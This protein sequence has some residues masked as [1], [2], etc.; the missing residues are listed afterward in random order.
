MDSAKLLPGSLGGKGILRVLVGDRLIKTR[1]CNSVKI[2][3]RVEAFVSNWNELQAFRVS[4]LSRRMR[5]DFLSGCAY[6]ADPWF[7]DACRG[8]A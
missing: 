4:G 7:W 3:A 5:S 2:S 6:A 1:I 8:H